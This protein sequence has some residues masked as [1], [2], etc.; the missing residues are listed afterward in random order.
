M[1]IIVFIAAMPRSSRGLVDKGAGLVLQFRVRI[2][3]KSLV[4]LGRASNFK[5]LLHYIRKPCCVGSIVGNPSDST[6]DVGSSSRNKEE[7]TLG[8]SFYLVKNHFLF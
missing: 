7:V 1:Y 5:M 2:S 4:M 8:E 6:T 3:Q